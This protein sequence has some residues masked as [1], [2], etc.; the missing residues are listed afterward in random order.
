MHD[1]HN[2]IERVLCIIRDRTIEHE[3]AQ[4]ERAATVE[5]QRLTDEA[6]AASE[7]KSAFLASMS[8]EIRTPLNAVIGFT[9]IILQRNDLAPDL[10]RQIR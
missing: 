10:A 2:H 6:K 7:A 3:R 9:G 5:A 4:A 1:G 8:H